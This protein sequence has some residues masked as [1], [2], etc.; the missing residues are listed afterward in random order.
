ML[1]SLPE[2]VRGCAQMRGWQGRGRGAVILVYHLVADLDRDPFRIAVSPDVFDA[3]MEVIATRYRP[4]MLAE[5]SNGL[6]TGAL[7]PR[8]VAVTFDDGYANNLTAA[9][10][11]LEAWSVPATVFVSTGY[12]GGSREFWWDELERL[13]YGVGHDPERGVAERQQRTAI[14]RAA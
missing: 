12:V 10:P 4:Q 7:P 8:S 2:L 14:C 3:Q 5:L 9:L 13:I 6:A 1:E 11:I